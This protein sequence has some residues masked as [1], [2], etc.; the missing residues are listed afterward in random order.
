MAQ[1]A[2]GRAAIIKFNRTRHLRTK[3]G[4]R[5]KADGLPCEQIAMSNGRCA[6]HGGKVPKGDHKWHKPLWPRGAPG[7]MK[8]LNRKLSDLQRAAKKREKR[9]AK[10]TPT[11]L[12]KY[13]AWQKSHQPGS[14]AARARTR[15]E[16]KD[17]REMRELFLK[18]EREAEIAAAIRDGKG[19]FA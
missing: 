19:V 7:A 6:W 13:R 16:R 8:K 18:V 15:R 3:C 5:R 9:V 1:I 12:A 2:V 14:A 17:A 4:A 11:E 10:M